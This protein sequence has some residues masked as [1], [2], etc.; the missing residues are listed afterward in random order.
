[1]RHA[2]AVEVGRGPLA[3]R[4]GFGEESCVI[5]NIAAVRAVS[6]TRLM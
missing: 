6:Y 2:E 4:A 3:V 1:M 5:L